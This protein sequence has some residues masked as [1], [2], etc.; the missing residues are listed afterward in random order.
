MRAGLLLGLYFA[1]FVAS[2]HSARVEIYGSSTYQKPNEKSAFNPNNSVLEI[3]NWWHQLELRPDLQYDFSNSHSLILRSRHFLEGRQEDKKLPDEKP[4]S[5][6]TRS[7]LTDAF[8]NSQWNESWQ[9]AIGLQNYQWGPAEIFSP[10][11]P[12]FHFL[13]EQRSFFFIQKGR[14]LARV[15]WNP[16]PTSSKWSV[17][18]LYEPIENR[19]PFWTAD[20]SFRPRSALK[21]ERQFENPI[22]SVALVAG[23]GELGRE[24]VGEY[25]TWS[26]EEGLSFYG[27]VKHQRG[28][29]H[30]R[31][32][33]GAFGTPDMVRDSDQSRIFSFGIFGFRWEGRVDFRQE[34]IWNEGGYDSEE[35]DRARSSALTPAPLILQNLRRFAAPGLE[36]RTRSYSYSSL[37]IPNLGPGDRTSLAIRWLTSLQEDSSALQLN[38]EYLWTDHTV[39]Q[40]EVLHFSGSKSSE[41]RLVNDTQAALGFRWTY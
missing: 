17:V 38:W 10:S 6:L 5:V 28:R 8:V 20:R 16:D 29:T 36:F 33:T 11:N 7:D 39:L 30:W 21:I 14:I 1:G 41:F 3:P 22:N 34:F 15:N 26:P 12:F 32:Q 40:A 13:N 9:T 18:G 24:F 25:F 2:A 19:D 35:W 31:P 37:R 27:D 23:Q 4:F